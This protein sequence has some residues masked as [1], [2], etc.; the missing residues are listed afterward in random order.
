MGTIEEVEP[1]DDSVYDWISCQEWLLA[2][3]KVNNIATEG[4]VDMFLCIVGPKT[5]FLHK[6]PVYPASPA[7][8]ALDALMQ[9]LNDH[10]SPEPFVQ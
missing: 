7:S 1:F 5:N 10:L 3:M 4:K 6:S 8:Q 2:F 9:A